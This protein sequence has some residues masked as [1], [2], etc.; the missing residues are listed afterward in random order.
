MRRRTTFIII[1]FVAKEMQH[2]ASELARGCSR[3]PYSE[4]VEPSPNK[5]KK[6]HV[7]I[8]HRPSRKIA[9]DKDARKTLP[10]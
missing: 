4:T 1:I 3:P 7:Y 6:E 9:D 5:R 8:V 10:W 2:G